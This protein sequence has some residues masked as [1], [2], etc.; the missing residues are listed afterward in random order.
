MLSS[1]VRAQRQAHALWGEIARG[2]NDDDTA[3]LRVFCGRELA[4]LATVTHRG[5]DVWIE[6]LYTIPAHRCKGVASAILD[7]VARWRVTRNKPQYLLVLVDNTDAHRLYLKHGFEETLG[8]QTMITMKR[9][10]DYQPTSTVEF[11]E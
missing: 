10:A 6:E 3:N 4:G 9:R 11:D 8:C 1:K 2:Y 5:D 7:F